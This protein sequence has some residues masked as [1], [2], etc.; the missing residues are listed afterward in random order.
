MSTI[1]VASLSR[2]MVRRSI[3]LLDMEYKP[4]E[5]AVELNASKE[6]VLKL[7]SAGAP[8]RKDAKGHYWIHGDTFREWLEKA[9]PKNIKAKHTFEDN[10]CWCTTCKSVVVFTEVRRKANVIYG[11]CPLGHNTARF[12]STK[13]KEKNGAQ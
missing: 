12:F 6:Q 2:A 1:R 3:R 13:H 9:A 5:L 7:V 11:N 4:A 8:A 10:T